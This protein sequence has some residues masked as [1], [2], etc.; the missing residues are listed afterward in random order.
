MAN[1]WGKAFGVAFGVAFGASQTSI[2]PILSQP[3]RIGGGFK[4]YYS[5][6]VKPRPLTLAE[7]HAPLA[8]VTSPQLAEITTQP[9]YIDD[10]A[11]AKSRRRQ[12]DEA[13]LLLL[14]YL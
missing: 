10:I 11:S 7:W 5:D 8:F 12:K 3:S 6:T 4:P 13:E 14:H 1:A 2:P 9:A